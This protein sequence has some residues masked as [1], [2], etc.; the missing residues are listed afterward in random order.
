[1]KNKKELDVL[2]DAEEVSSETYDD[3]DGSGCES[4]LTDEVF[5]GNKRILDKVEETNATMKAIQ[6]KV[7]QLEEIVSKSS[8]SSLESPRLSILQS[9]RVLSNEISCL[10]DRIFALETF[11]ATMINDI[12]LK[13]ILSLNKLM[14]EF[15][16]Q[17]IIIEEMR[18][19][20]ITLREKKIKKK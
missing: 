16:S 14:D 18:E 3:V 13:Y 17:K 12:N 4:P 6:K 5:I 2:E 7:V 10:K 9:P 8:S 1:M 19:E 15:S 11:Q 20:F